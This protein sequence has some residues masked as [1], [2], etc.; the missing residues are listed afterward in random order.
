MAFHFSLAFLAAILL[1]GAVLGDDSAFS[2]AL[3]GPDGERNALSRGGDAGCKSEGRARNGDKLVVLD[4]ARTTP[5]EAGRKSVSVMKRVSGQS[6]LRNRNE[7]RND[8]VG[9]GNELHD[10]PA[11]SHKAQAGVDDKYGMKLPHARRPATSRH[12]EGGLTSKNEKESAEVVDRKKELE[13]MVNGIIA[14]EAAYAGI[15]GD[16]PEGEYNGNYNG[17][18]RYDCTGSGGELCGRVPSVDGSPGRNVSVSGSAS[19]S[20]PSAASISGSGQSSASAIED[21]GSTN[22]D[23]TPKDVQEEREK[24]KE[25]KE[26]EEEEE[27]KQEKEKQKEK[28]GEEKDGKEEEEKQL[29]KQKSDESND[30]QEAN[31]SSEDIENENAPSSGNSAFL[32]GSYLSVLPVVLVCLCACAC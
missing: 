31:N 21:E 18:Y 20:I 30:G 5:S 28:N 26:K 22:N 11:T 9:V 1:N 6:S 27:E 10:Q 12:G 3:A 7:A 13:N 4:S 15:Y 8:H 23:N 24:G 16:N 17:D 2:G 14:E 29:G 19:S 25:E 32:C